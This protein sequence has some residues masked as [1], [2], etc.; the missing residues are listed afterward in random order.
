MLSCEE[1]LAPARPTEVLEEL[2]SIAIA[3]GWTIEE[4]HPARLFC[5]EGGTS[6]RIEPRKLEVS[7]E[8]Y[9]LESKVR[10]AMWCSGF[11]LRRYDGKLDLLK[12]LP[13]QCTR[14]NGGER[15]SWARW[16]GFGEFGLIGL[17]FAAIVFFVVGVT[18]D[19]PRWSVGVAVVVAALASLSSGLALDFFARRELK[20][21][22]RSGMQ[23]Q[24]RRAGISAI[25]A[26]IM[27][28]WLWRM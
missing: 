21:D 20:I 23:A 7:A 26:A 13:Y 9:R 17:S 11:S 27:L 19:L 15:P 6:V 25:I 12:A 14:L 28:I 5:L 16:I 24:L 3:K 8:D 2:R 18:Q 4:D 10:L 22:S 1:Y